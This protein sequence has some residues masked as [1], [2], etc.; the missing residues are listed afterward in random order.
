MSMTELE[1]SSEWLEQLIM[2]NNKNITRVLMYSGLSSNNVLWFKLTLFVKE[3]GVCKEKIYIV[4]FPPLR[5]EYVFHKDD[6]RPNWSDFDSARDK[7]LTL[8]RR[9]VGWD[10]VLV[11][12]DRN[13]D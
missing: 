2:Q 11:A 9:I 12:F 3:D 7:I 10:N 1:V 4:K 13:Y 8:C 6:Y 5:V